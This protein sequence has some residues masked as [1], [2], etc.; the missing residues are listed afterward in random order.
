MDEN[1]YGNY[2]HATDYQKMAN[3]S[4]YHYGYV[5]P[6][7]IVNGQIISHTDN[8]NHIKGWKDSGFAQL[9]C[10]ICDIEVKSCHIKGCKYKGVN[11]G[12]TKTCDCNVRN[13]SFDD[14][15]ICNE[16]YRLNFDVAINLYGDSI[17]GGHLYK[18][19]LRRDYSAILYTQ[20]FKQ[21]SNCCSPINNIKRS[22]SMLSISTSSSSQTDSESIDD[23]IPPNL[24]RGLD[25]NKYEFIHCFSC[26][27]KMKI[28]CIQTRNGQICG[29]LHG[30]CHDESKKSLCPVCNMETLVK[31]KYWELKHETDYKNNNIYLFSTITDSKDLIFGYNS[32][33]RPLTDYYIKGKDKNDEMLDF[34]HKLTCTHWNS[35]LYS[36]LEITKKMLINGSKVYVK[37]TQELDVIH[38]TLYNFDYLTINNKKVEKNT[39]Q[40][41]RKLV[42]P[43]DSPF[44]KNFENHST[45]TIDENS[46]EKDDD[47]SFNG[48]EI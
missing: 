24:I 6:V 14:F 27:Q 2:Y 36:T 8:F 38:N 41:N 42:T 17:H 44:L 37:P 47:D 26:G 21:E 25:V 16:C 19:N 20:A 1:S 7:G 29:N 28:L 35:I 4:S 23:F 12:I 18:F 13:K 46:S 34:H 11:D 10:V 32:H 33:Q 39:V 5:N 3:L 15:P 48:M 9:N 31:T 40:K 45:F 30:I 43:T 22:D